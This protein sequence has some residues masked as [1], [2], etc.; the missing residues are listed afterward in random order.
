M[1]SSERSQQLQAAILNHLATV[2]PHDWEE[3]KK[4]F[5]DI[6]SSTFWRHVKKVKKQLEK[7]ALPVRNADLFAQSDEA[8]DEVELEET[9]K[10]NAVFRLLKHT[11]RF[12]ELHADVLALRQHALD[13]EG[14]IQDAHLFA[15]TIRLRNQLLNDE[16]SVVEGV[17]R[18]DVNTKFFDAVIEAVAKASPEVSAEIMKSLYALH[19]AHKGGEMNRD[20]ATSH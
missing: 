11:Q 13:K 4:D 1:P 19:A 10:P 7:P 5:L 8:E 15:K 12:Y 2:G 18:T 17:N 16:L 3:I 9:P 20:S 6:P 14:R